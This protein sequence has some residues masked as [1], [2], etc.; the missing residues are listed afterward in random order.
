[1]IRGL[2]AMPDAMTTNSGSGEYTREAES[3]RARPRSHTTRAVRSMRLFYFYVAS[4][5]GFATGAA[6]L[7]VA[8]SLTG[9]GISIG[10]SLLLPLL[11]FAGFA[12]MGGAV[13]SLAYREARNR[14]SR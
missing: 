11:P 4:L 9:S 14:R 6:G 13:A 8:L 1:M 3:V 12:V 7:G 2:L 5:W 10:P